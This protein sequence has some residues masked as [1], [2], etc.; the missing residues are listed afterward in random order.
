MRTQTFLLLLLAWLT[1]HLA[2]A[3]PAA[4]AAVYEAYWKDLVFELDSIE[5][6]HVKYVVVRPIDRQVQ[7]LNLDTDYLR[8]YL[9]GQ[10]ETNRVYREHVQPTGRPPLSWLSY[11]WV[12]ARVLEQ[13]RAVGGLLLGVDSV[14]RGDHRLPGLGADSGRFRLHALAQDGFRSARR[15]FSGKGEGSDA[16]R[17][18]RRGYGIV[19]L[20]DVVFSSNGQRAAFFLQH[21]R[22]GLAGWGGVIFMKKGPGGWELDFKLQFWIS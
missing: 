11:P 4:V 18:H 7:R 12:L 8:D 14:L 20:S 17:P 15:R 19:E 1:N 16:K 22:N 9:A 5:H 13:D 2:L 3:Q 10:L 6:Q 21:Y